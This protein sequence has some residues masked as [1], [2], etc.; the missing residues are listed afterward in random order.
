MTK[1]ET[2]VYVTVL[3][4]DNENDPSVLAL[5]GAS[6]AIMLSDIP[7]QGPIG[8]VRMGRIDGEF[9]VNPTNSQM[10]ESDINM[11]LTLSLIHI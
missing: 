8:A 1:V 11:V 2:Q 3:S 10:E 5:N 6:A 9:V 4:F 7:F